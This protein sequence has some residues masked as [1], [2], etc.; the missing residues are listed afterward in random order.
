MYGKYLKIH[1]FLGLQL[2]T[3]SDENFRV[4]CCPTK[5][6]CAPLISDARFDHFDLGIQTKSKTYLSE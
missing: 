4:F 2:T 1:K 6:N 5:K 3:S